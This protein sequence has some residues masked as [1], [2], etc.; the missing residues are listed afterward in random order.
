MALENRLEDL[1][2]ELLHD[3]ERI[4]EDVGTF[5]GEFKRYLSKVLE[6]FEKDYKVTRELPETCLFLPRDRLEAPAEKFLISASIMVTQNRSLTEHILDDEERAAWR[7][8]GTHFMKG[9]IGPDPDQDYHWATTMS[10]T[11][12]VQE[13]YKPLGKY[14][15]NSDS[16]AINT[17]AGF[18]VAKEHFPLILHP[19]YHYISNRPHENARSTFVHEMTHAYIHKKSDF[20]RFTGEMQAIGE[21]ATQVVN[22]FFGRNGWPPESYYEGEGALDPEI[23][24]AARQAFLRSTKNLNRSRSVSK[25]RKEAVRAINRIERGEDPIRALREEDD[26][27]SR[28]IRVAMHTRKKTVEEIRDDLASLGL[29]SMIGGYDVASSYLNSATRLSKDSDFGI[30]LFREEIKDELVEPTE[31]LLELSKKPRRLLEGDYWPDKW[32]KNHEKAL[33]EIFTGESW[34]DP[35]AFPEGETQENLIFIME[36]YLELI[37]MGLRRAKKLQAMSE[38]IK[39]ESEALFPEYNNTDFKKDM[40]KIHE[41]AEELEKDT[42]RMISEFNSAEETVETAIT[43]LKELGPEN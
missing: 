35:E 23:M 30:M 12:Q 25:V 34:T 33:R 22:D 28:M 27:R 14:F 32:N 7:S 17:L 3:E 42:E 11:I 26:F 29:I 18:D 39:K 15:W 31:N 36:T 9:Q 43:R 20:T 6:H 13:D 24:Q 37:D 2:H 10:T 41:D 16:I 5:Y 19:L 4:L 38:E 1:K 21:A 8:F 40:K